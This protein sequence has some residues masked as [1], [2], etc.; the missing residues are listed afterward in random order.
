[1]EFALNDTQKMFKNTA[2][3]VFKETCTISNLRKMEEAGGGHSPELY[4]QMAELGFLGL[5]IPEEYGGV[6]GNLLDLALVVEEAGWA[7]LSGP[8]Y[9]T[10]SY[11]II[12]LLQYGSEEQKSELLPKIASGEVIVTSAFSEADVHYDL[13]Y[14]STEA[15]NNQKDE[16]IISGTKLFVAHADIANYFLVLARTGKDKAAKDGLSLFLVDSN[17]P[18]VQ[19][20]PMPSI[21]S[22]A[23]FEVNFSGVSVDESAMLASIGQGL[24]AAQTINLNAT[25]LQAIEMS[26]ILQRAV[27]VTADYVKERRQFGRAIG[28]FQAVQHR[29]SDMLTIV[30]GGRLVAYQAIWKLNEGI[31]AEKEVATAKAYLCKEGQN[32]LVGAHQLHGGMGIDLDYPLQYCF[33]RFK[34]KQV[35]LGSAS[36]HIETIAKSLSGTVKE[37]TLV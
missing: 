27:D 36:I 17:Q 14:V 23:L 9:S 15:V 31:N 1:M 12:P 19:I 13:Q 3:K 22:D 32:V 11:G 4:K 30:E 28:T 20:S 37:K 35:D 24:D 34:S 7:A 10:I 21:G 6:G 33:R 16:Y 25:A 29:L 5:I 26:G 18:G 8:F 2:Q